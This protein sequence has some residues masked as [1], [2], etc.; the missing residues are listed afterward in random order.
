[1]PGT[2]S[3]PRY[4]RPVDEHTLPGVASILH[5]DMDAFF[6]LRGIAR[7]SGIARQNL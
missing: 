4:S 6:R 1:M 7:A 2:G 5:V 3:L